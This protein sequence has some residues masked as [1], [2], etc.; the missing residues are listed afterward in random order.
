MTQVAIY[1][2]LDG[3]L[4]D[5]YSYSHAAADLLLK[6]LKEAAIP[7][8]PVS[9]K[10]RAEILSL[11]EELGNNHPFISENGAAVFIPLN[12]FTEPPDGAELNG[13]YWVKSFSFPRDHW[14]KKIEAISNEFVK[15][16]THF[17][18]LSTQD[19]IS[20]TGLA[21]EK[22]QQ[23]A[24]REFGEPVHWC[25]SEEEKEK[26][27]TMLQQN[28]AHVLVGGR[29]IHV[30]GDCSKGRALL[31]LN[32][33]YQNQVGGKSPLSIAIGDSQNDVAMLEVADYSLVIRS[34]THLPPKL[35][36]SG[37]SLT[38]SAFGPVGWDEGVREIL[39]LLNRQ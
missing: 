7:V 25:G 32:K 23:A 11:R 4:L 9:S 26:F 14:L 37:P 5:H 2:D 12:Y 27:I 35:I 28:G 29:F 6:E 13:D 10:T 18:Q 33:L 15:Q 20:L 1:T 16:F 22:A 3:S 34:P 24:Q 21:A 30:S 31:W 38:S 36:R 8:I 39:D 19:I 17:S